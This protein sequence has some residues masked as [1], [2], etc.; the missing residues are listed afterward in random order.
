MTSVIKKMPMRFTTSLMTVLLACV[1][2]PAVAQTIKLA[3]VVPEGSAWM[4]DM[5][6]GAK[7][8]SERTQ[9]RVKFKFYGGGVQGNDKQVLRKMRIGQLH[10][11][12]FTSNALGEFQ[13]DSVLYAMPMLFSNLEEVQF[14]RQ[15][16]DD[17]LRLLLEGAGYVNFG[18]AGG[19]FAHLMSNHPIA[20]LDD[21]NGLKVWIPDGD[22]LSYGA[23]KA[24]GISPVTMPLTDVLTGLQTELI[25]TIMGPPAATIVLQWN[26]GVSY[27]TE[28]PLAYIFAMLVID[29]KVFDRIQTDDQ[30]IVREVMERVYRGF[31]QQGNEDNEK[32]YQ[33]LLDDG[34]KPVTP[35]QGQIPV[36]RDVVRASNRELAREGVVDIALLNEIECYI[37]AYRTGRQADG[38]G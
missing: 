16:M 31:D 25:D 35:D 34:M 11:G 13:K 28:L 14:V 22:R 7:E 38:C 37:D 5:R 4:K 19:G 36:W 8:I 32:A 23:A 15:R 1:A 24:L 9:D 33:A 27:I 30:V 3:T 21:M 29:K 12:A 20:N 26:T 18:F 17:K 6:A 2:L 10:G